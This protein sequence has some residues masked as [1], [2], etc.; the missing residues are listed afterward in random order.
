MRRSIRLIAVFASATLLTGA[1]DG[2]LGAAPE[3]QAAT[4]VPSWVIPVYYDDEATGQHRACTGIVLSKTKTLAT[5]DCFT[6]MDAADFEWEYDLGTGQLSGGSGGGATY[7]SH[8]QYDAATRRAAVSVVTRRTPD[9]SGKPVLASASDSALWAPGAKAT[10]YSWAGLDADDAPRARHSEQ[11]EIKSAADC[12]ALLGSALPSGA[13]CSVPAPGAA[14]V[15]DDDQC[16]GDAGGALVAG[17]KL[18][19]TSATRS[20]GCVQDGVRVYTRVASYRSMITNATTDTDIDYRFGGSFLA[21][22]PGELLDVC[23]TDQDRR[24]WG[25]SV[26]DA[27]SFWV[28]GYTAVLQAGDLNGD[29]FGDLLARTSGGTLYRVPSSEFGADFDRRA[30]IGGGW[31]IYSRLVTVR[32]ISGDGKPDL[33]GRDSA[34]VLWLYRA[35]GKGGFLTRS[36]IGGGWNIYTALAGRGDVSGDGIPDLVAR[37]KAG[38]LWLYRGNGKGNFATRT[39]VGGGWN[40]YNAIVGSGDFDRNGRQDIVGRTPTGA[41]YLYN[42]DHKGNFSTPK[43]LATTAMKNFVSLS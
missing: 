43:K 26:D 2:V 40:M 8:P 10:F 23:V 34:G 11:V 38:V 41:L 13:V 21:R 16:F 31:N 33:I 22:E 35:D 3:A 18:I 20:T 28:S 24:L 19:A 7:R 42:A 14:P 25:C 5:P 29:S 27:G 4:S 17:G 15:A 37:D 9:N 6:G 30:R 1:V 36:R 32:D 12:A 39:R